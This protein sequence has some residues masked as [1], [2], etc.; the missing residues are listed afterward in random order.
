MKALLNNKKFLIFGI[1]ALLAI[2]YS[3]FKIIQFARQETIHI[4]VAGPMTGPSAANGKAYI[5]G[6]QLF[7]E[8]INKQGGVDGKKIVLDIYDDQNNKDLAKEVSEKIVQENKALIVIGHNSSSCSIAAGGIY[9]DARIPAISPASTNVEVTRGKE[10]YYRTIFNDNSQGRFL[11]NYLKKVLNVNSVK[12]VHEDQAYGKNLTRVFESTA[13]EIGLKIVYKKE[14]SSKDEKNPPEKQFDKIVEELSN[15]KDN[16]FIFTAMGAPEGAKFLK[17]IKDKNLRNPIISPDSFASQGFIKE[18]ENFKKEKE[19]P[20]YYS[21]GIHVTTPLIFDNANQKAQDFKEKYISKYNLDPDWRAVYA[22]DSILVLIEAIQKGKIS[23]D[24]DDIKE[25]REKIKNFLASIDQPSDAI[26]GATGYNYFDENGD[27]PK[28]VSIGIYK[29]HNIISA[30]TQLQVVKDPAEITNSEEALKEGRMLLVDDKI[31]YRTNVV[32]TGI[33]VNEIT[34]LNVSDQTYTM[35]FY[36]WFRYNGDDISPE[37]IEFG[38]SIQ[39]IRLGKEIEYIKNDQMTYKAYHVKGR[40]RANSLPVRF[41]LENHPI[42][43]SFH[44][45]SLNRNNLIYVIDMVGMGISGNQKKLDDF[46]KR[47]QIL[48]PSTGYVIATDWFFQ[49]TLKKTSLGSPRYLNMIDPSVEYS[50]FNMG[51]RIKKDEVSFRRVISDKFA[52]YI[53]IFSMLGMMGIGVLSGLK[54]YKD[55]SNLFWF[56]QTILAYIILASSEV[57]IIERLVER[58][59]ISNIKII[60]STYDLLWWIVPAISVTQ[61][62]ER[63][64]WIPLEKRTEHTIPTVVRKFL[65]FII[66]LLTVFGIVAFVYDQKITSLLATSGMV[67]MIIGLAIQVNISNVFSGIAINV[68][69]PFRVGD[70]VKIGSLDEGKVVDIT[71]R[72]TRI[73]LRNQ[74]ILSIPNS[75]ASESAIHN[76]SLP[77][78]IV[79]MWFTI[80]IDPKVPPKRVVK[81]LLDALYSSDVVLRNPGPYARFN[82]YTDWSAD[83]LFGYCFKDYGKKNAARKVVWNNIWIHLHRAG[84]NPAFLKSQILLQKEERELISDIRSPLN[85]I[86]E[87]D[88]FETFTKDEKE[89]LSEKLK[90]LTFRPGEFIV[91]AGDDTNF[92]M[93]VIL[94]G[95]V[96]VQAPLETGE[97]IEVARLGAGNFFGEMSL[98]TG[99]I[100][101]ANIIADSKTHVFEITKEDI[102]PLLDA[103]PEI[104][105]SVKTVVKERKENLQSK[106]QEALYVPPPKKESFWKKIKKKSYA[107][108]GLQKEIEEEEPKE[109]VQK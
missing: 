16:H 26:E 70:W 8:P 21:N 30:L 86:E 45:K 65:N 94:E 84:I 80:H 75:M 43:V 14:F 89:Y 102:Q 38:N 23:G 78:G 35:E 77:D 24:P 90:P 44:H 99:A 74:T 46:T 48:S 79:E 100:R 54:S 51:V 67:A 82:E 72:T 104:A 52:L 40:F 81:V 34:D 15:Q 9:Q 3:L 4:A 105:N 17:K 97:F 49:D 69:R 2:I 68:E 47:S 101:T 57:E 20:G 22:Y 106:K 29:N 55:K 37:E 71:W 63:F 13:K 25:D 103:H 19:I 109:I 31:L 93:F 39:K 91:K 1:L 42:G 96:S 76:F 95:V 98:L 53:L 56:L 66:Y 12:I 108:L 60:L 32:Y 107:L 27:S 87:I 58:N 59:S 62:I 73:R 85:V 64:V 28:P 7:L 11:A 5:N 88:M 83:Y 50:R 41:E 18:L 33:E 10:W 6:I 36:M 92:S 61:A